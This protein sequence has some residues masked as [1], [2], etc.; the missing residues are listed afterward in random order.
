MRIVKVFVAALLICSFYRCTHPIVENARQEPPSKAPSSEDNSGDDDDDKSGCG[1]DD[2]THSATIAYYN[3]STNY[4]AT[5][6]VDVEVDGCQVTQINFNN[7]GYLGPNHIAPTD[8]DEDGDAP[9]VDDRG[10][11]YGVHIDD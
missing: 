4:S 11:S 7:G 6:T 3:P 9:V 2:G 8:I 1:V 5:Y 10:R